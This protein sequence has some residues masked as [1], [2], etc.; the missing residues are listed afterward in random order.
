MT[1][2]AYTATGVL[3][4]AALMALVCWG[5][6]PREPKPRPVTCRWCRSPIGR[7]EKKVTIGPAGEVSL[8]DY[9]ARWLID[10]L[11]SSELMEP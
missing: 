7:H 11:E 3:L 1:P 6:W 5:I 2:Y 9:C 4:G 8:H 10:H